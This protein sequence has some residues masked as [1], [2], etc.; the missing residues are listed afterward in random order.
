[1][2]GVLNILKPPGMTSHDVVSVIRRLAGTKRVGHAGTLDPGAAGVLPLCLGQA[3]RVSEYLL[4]LPKSYRAEL[5]LGVATTTE[6]AAGEVTDRKPVPSLTADVVEKALEHFVGPQLQTPPMYSAVRAGGHRL[7][8]LARRGVEVQR[9]PRKIHIYSIRLL[10]LQGKRMMFDVSCSRGTYV[11]TLCREIAEALG[12][13]G[14]M[15]FLVRTAVGPFLLQET[16]SLE[17]AAQLAGKK[18]L[19][20]ALLAVDFGLQH[21]S[22]AVL[23]DREAERLQHGGFIPYGEK[24]PAGRDIRVY[25]QDGRF[26]ALAE[27]RDGLL[28]PKKVFHHR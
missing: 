12:T 9:Q 24:L 22:R 17:E 3:T 16:L 1:M 10:L 14:H 8:E 18:Q 5:A 2:N 21:L 11:R 4:A 25:R 6:D 26:L 13:A 7:Y 23:T 28:R 19:S 15:S 20:S 27:V